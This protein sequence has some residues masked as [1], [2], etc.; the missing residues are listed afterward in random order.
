VKRRRL[1]RVAAINL[2]LA[3]SV[4]V[5]LIVLWSL[6]RPEPLQKPATRGFSEVEFTYVC[7]RGHAFRLQGQI[8]PP[9]CPTCELPSYPHVV[10]RCENHGA[11]EV[12]VRVAVGDDGVVR[13][14]E[15]QLPGKNWVPVGEPLECPICNRKMFR[16]SA[17]PLKSGAARSPRGGG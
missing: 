6:N 13:A 15:L 9:L 7:P 2:V 4:A 1:T 11:F 17:D 14:S 16:D 3:V 12:S 8:T 10:F 5:V